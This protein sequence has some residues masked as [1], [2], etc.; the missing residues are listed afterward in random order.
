MKSKSNK[1]VLNLVKKIRGIEGL[2]IS[3]FSLGIWGQ[4]KLLIHK[5]Q[6]EPK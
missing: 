4:L 2:E 5:L 1:I 3:A 6:V